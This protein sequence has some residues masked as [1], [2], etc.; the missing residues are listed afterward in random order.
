MHAL[1]D[2]LTLLLDVLGDLFA[3]GQA[4]IADVV[5]DSM[6]IPVC[7]RARAALPDGA[8]AGVLWLLS[9]QT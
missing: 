4:A 2:W 6:P 5:I 9:R 8:R 7:K 1:A 3:H